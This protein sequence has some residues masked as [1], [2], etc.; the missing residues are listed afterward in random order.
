MTN[1]RRRPIKPASQLRS[2]CGPALGPELPIRQVLPGDEIKI[3]G[4]KHFGPEHMLDEQEYPTIDPPPPA[5][6]LPPTTVTPTSTEVNAIVEEVKTQVIA[7][8]QSQKKQQKTK[9]PPSP[10]ATSS[11]SASPSSTAPSPPLAP[12]RPQKTKVMMLW[13]MEASLSVAASFCS[14]VAR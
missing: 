11:S 13:A 6:Q 10:T 2:M 14:G 7:R 5:K 8:R 3:S 1:R 12:Q 4:S 9:K